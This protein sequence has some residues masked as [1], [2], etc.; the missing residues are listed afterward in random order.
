VL[1]VG[2]HASRALLAR[3]GARACMHSSRSGWRIA[4][5]AV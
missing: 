1:A 4:G 3:F 2:T 5:D